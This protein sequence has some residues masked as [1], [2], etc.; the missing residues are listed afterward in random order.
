MICKDLLS[1]KWRY[2]MLSSR[3][4]TIKVSVLYVSRIMI[5]AQFNVALLGCDS[6]LIT[7]QKRNHGNITT[8]YMNS[9]S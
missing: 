8:T 2:I 5:R 3:Y 7:K 6:V 4:K 9:E 1:D